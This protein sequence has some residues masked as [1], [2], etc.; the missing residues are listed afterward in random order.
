MGMHRNSN[1]AD[2][3][4]AAGTRLLMAWEQKSP[5]TFQQSPAE[6]LNERQSQK[7]HVHTR[8][9]PWSEVSLALGAV[10]SQ[11]WMSRATLCCCA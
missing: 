1:Q 5:A 2:G 7:M 4:T 9:Q 3:S 11:L 10:Q 6:P 8:K